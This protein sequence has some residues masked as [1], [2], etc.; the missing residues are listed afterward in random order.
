MRLKTA[1]TAMALIA[2][3]ATGCKTASSG[4]EVKDIPPGAVGLPVQ[5]PAVFVLEGAAAKG[6]YDKL[7]LDEETDTYGSNKTFYGFASLYCERTG[8]GLPAGAQGFP[9][10]ATFRCGMGAMIPPGA[11]GFPPPP[12]LKVDGATARELF[13]AMT[14]EEQDQGS[15][16]SKSFQGSVAFYCGYTLENGLRSNDYCRLT[17][18]DQDAGG[19]P[20]GAQGLPVLPGD[21]DEGGGIPPGAQGLPNFGDEK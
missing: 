12:F 21:D 10:P 13:K 19:M 4:A 8:G 1:C 18:D 16:G 11:Q 2:L 3:S 7:T 17:A 9:A 6:V 20:P 14:V 5:N 15:S